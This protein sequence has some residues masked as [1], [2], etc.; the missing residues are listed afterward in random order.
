MAHPSQKYITFL[1][2]KSRIVNT[3]GTP[4]RI[5]EELRSVHALSIDPDD[6]ELLIRDIY[7]PVGLQYFNYRH[8]AT[9]EFMK[10]QGLYEVWNPA[11]GGAEL[12]H[13]LNHAQATET[14]QILLMGRIHP[15]EVV[16]KLY[17]KH[18]L[19]VT[20]EAI[21]LFKR[22]LWDVD[23]TSYSEWHRLLKT[24]PLRTS[25]LACL[26]G[27]PD[28]AR[29]RAG[30]Q[31]MI[32]GKKTL[33]DAYRTI[34]FMIEGLRGRPDSKEAASMIAMLSKELAGLYNAIYGDGAGLED[35]LREFKA[36]MLQPEDPKI[37]PLK[38][39]APLGNF[40]NSGVKFIE[41]GQ[42]KRQEEMEN[43]DGDADTGLGAGPRAQEADA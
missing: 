22:V 18:R 30:F 42:R 11:V 23:A 29:F 36:F 35:V 32:E 39:L 3:K 1:Y 7:V 9:A 15:K 41:D 24:A 10:S 8:H 21:E 38:D 33:K 37:K 17:R 27:S 12:F 26:H 19:S 43:V 20:T 34:H 13:L 5:N 6:F 14:A 28:Q 31:P 25:F 40:S 2:I 16:D 4:S